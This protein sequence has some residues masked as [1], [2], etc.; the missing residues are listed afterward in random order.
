[1]K[2]VAIGIVAA[3]FAVAVLASSASHAPADSRDTFASLREV[4]WLGGRRITA[5]SLRGRV[6]VVS[7]WTFDCVNCR[8]T[9]PALKRLQARAPGGGYLLLG[10][11]TP[12][13]E[14]EYDRDNLR[15]A[16][17]TLGVTWP[18][19]QDNRAMAWGAFDVHAWPT[20]IVVDGSGRRR[21]TKVG[22]LHVD[23]PAWNEL[24]ALL[25]RLV[26]EAR[27]ARS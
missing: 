27:A 17:A 15:R 20:T 7:F 2:R 22:E 6:V 9:L 23:S 26:R 21:W 16:V 12:E 24:E 19:A 18:V 3:T 11:H 5:E 8:R 10:I 4:S 14:H 1:M 13:L 25:D